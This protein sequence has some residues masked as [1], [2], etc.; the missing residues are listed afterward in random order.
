ADLQHFVRV[1]RG[2]QVLAFRLYGEAV[3]AGRED[4]PFTE[5]PMLGGANLLRGY[6]YE[7]FRDRVAIQGSFEYQWDLSRH[8][9]ASLFTDVGRVYPALDDISLDDL[10][11]GY[12][13]ALEAH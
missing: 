1:G 12:G 5:L 2:P 11:W 4:I 9:F 3:S 13:L 8:V 6:A 10:R 7:R